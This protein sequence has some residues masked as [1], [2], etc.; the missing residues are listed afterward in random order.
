MTKSRVAL[1]MWYSFHVVG[2]IYQFANGGGSLMRIGVS[3]LSVIVVLALTRKAGRWAVA[4]SLVYA[5]ISIIFGILMFGMGLWGFT[6]PEGMN[7]IFV[8]F[9]LLVTVASAWTVHELRSDLSPRAENNG[10]PL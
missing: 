3:V 4:T 2:T 8:L 7:T 9:G 1:S 10:Q 5:A 6:Q